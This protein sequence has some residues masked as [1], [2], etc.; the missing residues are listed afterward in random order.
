MLDFLKKWGLIVLAV[1]I[2]CTFGAIYLIRDG[3]NR[4]ALEDLVSQVDQKQLD[5]ESIER[6]AN[7]T[8]MASLKDVNGV[9]VDRIR[10]DNNLAS[11]FFESLLTWVDQDAYCDMQSRIT[12]EYGSVCS[13]NFKKSFLPEI[14]GDVL[15][16]GS[17]VQEFGDAANM[18]F[19]DMKSY[20]VDFD[21]DTGLYSY[22]ALVYVTSTDVN[23]LTG[24]GL[25]IFNYTIDSDEEFVSIDGDAVY[26]LR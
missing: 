15:V 19:E 23:D 18:K 1:L 11:T 9:D 8:H 25:C 21:S 10:L 4:R 5:Y 16:N 20:L 3:Q 6:D 2:M 26:G 7:N 17:V 14:K 24:S 22:Y 12:S 13:E